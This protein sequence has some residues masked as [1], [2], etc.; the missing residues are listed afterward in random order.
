MKYTA[1]IVGMAFRPP[2]A[3]VLNQ[4]AMGHSLECRRQPENEYDPNAIQVF[5]HDFNADSKLAHI[6]Q[7]CLEDALPDDLP[8]GRNVWNKSALTNPLFLGFVAA[9]T[10]EAAIIAKAMDKAGI[11]SIDG[12]LSL[13]LQGSPAV[14]LEIGDNDYQRI[15][16]GGEDQ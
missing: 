9:K 8:A 3:K 1:P 15:N 11:N 4:L 16:E 10:G 14:S 13:T 5:L 7:E 6:Y 2:S 12:R